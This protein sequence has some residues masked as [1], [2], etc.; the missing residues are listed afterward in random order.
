LCQLYVFSD[1]A[2]RLRQTVE[3]AKEQ[4]GDMKESIK[5]ATRAAAAMEEFAKS[6]TR[7]A[8]AA[9]VSS[10]AATETVT[11]VKDSMAKQLRAYLCVNFHSAGFQ[12]PETKF[13]FEVR[14]NL[15]NAGFTPGY[16]VSF[17]SH[18]DVLEFPLS[19]N[20]TFPLPD[21][22]SGSES[23]LGHG[24]SLIMGGIVSRIYS[25]EEGAEIRA[26]LTKR[27]YI[28]GTANYEDVYHIQRYINF[29]FSVIWL[30][31]DCMG[32]LTKGHNDAD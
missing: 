13:L 6:A 15:I 23:T 12:N 27:L 4:S 10:R 9:I 16:K 26:G 2:K 31:K 5:Q 24:Q 28:Y 25:E 18:V 32:V 1:Q 3:A 19:G 17:R 21:A 30:G 20:F 11:T 29:C 22:P 14:L 8:E 7:G